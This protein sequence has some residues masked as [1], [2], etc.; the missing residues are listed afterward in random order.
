MIAELNRMKGGRVVP[1]AIISPFLQRP[2]LTA[3]RCMPIS[4][5]VKIY[6]Y[7]DRPSGSNLSSQPWL[8]L[9]D[10]FLRHLSFPP[11]TTMSSSPPTS[12]FELFPSPGSNSIYDPYVGGGTN[13]I[14]A[15]ALGAVVGVVLLGGF[16]GAL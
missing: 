14:V 6:I 10:S 8:V 5:L 15:V 12:S 13:S 4:L 7:R 16:L 11:T 9:L 1:L 3:S 2:R